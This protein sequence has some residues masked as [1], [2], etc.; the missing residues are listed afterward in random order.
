MRVTIDENVASAI[1]VLEQI[2]PHLKK[3]ADVFIDKVGYKLEAESKRAAPVITGNLRR[4]II[5]SERRQAL[6]AHANYSK[7]VHGEPF[8]QNRIR[9]RETPFITNAI[10]NSELFIRH[11][12]KQLL[13]RALN[14]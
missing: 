1:R 3:E 13:R 2:P 7:Y 12:A 10:T 11:E 6:D 14:Q 9:R 8:Y 4:S 5:Y